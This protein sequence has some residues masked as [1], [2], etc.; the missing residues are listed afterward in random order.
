MDSNGNFLKKLGVSKTQ[1]NIIAS[2]FSLSEK[3]DIVKGVLKGIL[4]GKTFE[5]AIC[6]ISND[7]DYLISRCKRKWDF[8]LAYEKWLV[9]S[10]LIDILCEIKCAKKL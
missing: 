9:K 10:L 1:F 4:N 7:N 6:D 2:E 8:V 3:R 5:Q